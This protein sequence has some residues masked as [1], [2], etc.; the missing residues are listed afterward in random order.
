[1][2]VF[3]QHQLREAL[4]YSSTGGQSLHLHRL[5]GPGA[6]ACF[7]RDLAAGGEIAHLFDQDTDRLTATA[8][9]LGVRVVVVERPGTDKQHVDLCGAPLRRALATVRRRP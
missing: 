7:R 1:M 8:R 9:R 6:P 4:G 5:A 3:R 2:R